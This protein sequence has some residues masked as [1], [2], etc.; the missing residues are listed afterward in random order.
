[1]EL[2]RVR[3]PVVELEGE[4]LAC[5]RLEARAVPPDVLRD[6]VNEDTARRSEGIAVTRTGELVGGGSVSASAEAD[7]GGPE[8]VAEAGGGDACST[9]EAAGLPPQETAPTNAVDV[10]TAAAARFMACLPGDEC[11]P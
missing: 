11:D 9:G 7:A 2:R 8:A 6:E 5:R 4:R 3:I 10:R 1:V